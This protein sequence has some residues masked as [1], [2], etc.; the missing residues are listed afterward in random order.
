[1]AHSGV[2]DRRRKSDDAGRPVP[3]PDRLEVDRLCL[4]FATF[5][6]EQKHAKAEQCLGR[7]GLDGSAVGRYARGSPALVGLNNATQ[8]APQRTDV[9]G[10]D[11]PGLKRVAVYLLRFALSSALMCEQIADAC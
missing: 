7:S 10:F 3:G 1:V 6:L 11:P 4:A 9:P 5:L 2:L 8:V